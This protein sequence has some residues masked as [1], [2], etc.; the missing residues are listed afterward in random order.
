MIMTNNLLKLAARLISLFPTVI[1]YYPAFS[2]LSALSL[3]ALPL[4]LDL[5]VIFHRNITCGDEAYASSE[6]NSK[7]SRVLGVITKFNTDFFSCRC[8]VEISSDSYRVT[9]VI[10]DD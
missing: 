7:G 8:G 9:D 6:R 5:C 3:D 2:S 10:D 1:L 4:E